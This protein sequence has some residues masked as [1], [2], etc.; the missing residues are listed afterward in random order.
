M[1]DVADKQ[2]EEISR[3][4]I[5]LNPSYLESGSRV[6]KVRIR[7]I[8]ARLRNLSLIDHD[9]AAIA[10]LAKYR[11]WRFLIEFSSYVRKWYAESCAHL[12]NLH[13][14]WSIRS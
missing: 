2:A 6:I 9:V 1:K 14:R 13:F 10:Y 12:T 3:N 7:E 8:S 11:S 5:Q 4:F